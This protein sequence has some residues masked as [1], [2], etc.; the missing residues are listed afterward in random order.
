VFD[1]FVRLKKYVNGSRNAK[2][3]ENL[4]RKSEMFHAEREEKTKK[5][6]MTKLTVGFCNFANAPKMCIKG[7]E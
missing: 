4:S 1:I 3:Q 5:K 2:F 7:I 6:T